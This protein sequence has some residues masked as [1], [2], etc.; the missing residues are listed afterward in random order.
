ME[1]FDIGCLSAQ[2]FD[3]RQ[4]LKPFVHS[5]QIFLYDIVKIRKEFEIGTDR[6]TKIPAKIFENFPWKITAEGHGRGLG[7]CPLGY[8]FTFLQFFL[9]ILQIYVR[10]EMFSVSMFSV[11]MLAPSFAQY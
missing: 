4:L 8:K 2:N 11:S 5:S 7:G 9:Q 3:L 10:V 6:S 1:I